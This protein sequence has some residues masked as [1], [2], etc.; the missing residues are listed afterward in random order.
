MPVNGLGHAPV[1][2]PQPPLVLLMRCLHLAMH[3]HLLSTSS[4]CLQAGCHVVS[5]CTPSTLHHLLLHH[6][7]T[8]LF[9]TPRLHLHWLVVELHLI[10]LP[11]PPILLSTLL[12]LDVPLP[13]VVPATPPLICLLFTPTGYCIASCVW[14][15]VALLLLSG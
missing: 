3:R 9:L 4:P 12:P 13:Y 8:C 10:A 2:V 7:F 15:V 1:V 11:L 14:L 5:N 6:C